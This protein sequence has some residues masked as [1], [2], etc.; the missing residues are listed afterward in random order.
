MTFPV[1]AGVVVLAS[2]ATFAIAELIKNDW[3]L[4]FAFVGVMFVAASVLNHFGQ[5]RAQN[6]PH[7]LYKASRL[8]VDG[9][10]R[11][12][13]PIL[14]VTT[15]ILVMLIVFATARPGERG[16]PL[17]FLYA[18]EFLYL[19]MPQITARIAVRRNPIASQ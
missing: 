15:L 13:R 6:E 12:I 11:W 4:V 2:A 14:V 1:L 3:V 17:P 16:S 18:A 10:T 19:V 8:P 9:S 7:P 5:V